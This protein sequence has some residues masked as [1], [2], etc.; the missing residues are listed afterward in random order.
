M[1]RFILASA[2][3]LALQAR[4]A[5]PKSA[6]ATAEEINA[7][8]LLTG[9]RSVSP[10]EEGAPIPYGAFM[11]D[12]QPETQYEPS[13]SDNVPRVIQL[14]EPFDL[15]R[16]EVINSNNEK[17]YPGISVKQLRVEQGPAATGPWQ[18]VADWT[19]AK[20]TKPQSRPVSLKNV[21]Y[22]RVSLVSNHGNDTYIGIDEVQAWGKRSAPRKIQ[23]TGAWDTS[24]GQMVLT[25]TG[26]RVTGCY[27]S[28]E[29]KAGN[30]T[31][32]GTVEGAVFFGRY[33]EAN[34][35]GG[36][37][38]G[39]LAFALTQEGDLS[40]VWGSGPNDRN[41]RWDG[42]KRS[43]PSSITCE[44]P[45]V[46]L[47][48]ELK[49]KGRVVLHG[50]LFDTGKDVIRPE[51]IPVLQALAGAMKATPGTYL[52]EGHTDDRGGEAANQTL[53]E[54]RAASVK[55][56]LTGKGV[57]DKSLRTQGF[58][59]SRP[60]MPNTSEAGRAANR[61]VEVVRDEQ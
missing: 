43:E 23:F 13:L 8:S 29:T 47:A 46:A 37:N 12:G 9:A 2:L 59:M 18:L 4:S 52:I 61:R 24:Y 14:A 55:K 32:E 6:T 33:H 56:W 7:L 38:G 1:S 35:S 42:K 19:L 17:D 30:N 54:K 15:T 48:E 58:G 22:L 60:A 11:L 50:I 16:L 41:A 36:G 21:R 39:T 40:G 25:Q 26:Q 28:S 44:K 53:S 51:S 49:S 31:V 57:P 34:E 20:G 45:E 10:D 27:G 5:P 3:L